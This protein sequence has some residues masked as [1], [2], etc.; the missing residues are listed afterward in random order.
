[1]NGGETQKFQIEQKGP[2]Y[3][4]RTKKGNQYFT[5]DG[6]Q[7]ASKVYLTTKD[8]DQNQRFRI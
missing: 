8:L 7:N 1:M 4:I 3:F 5:V 6:P 2:D